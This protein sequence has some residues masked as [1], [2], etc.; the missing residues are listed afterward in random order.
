VKLF[1]DIRGVSR[2]SLRLRDLSDEVF[3]KTETQNSM[4]KLF[5]SVVA[6]CENLTMIVSVEE[7]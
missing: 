2:N 1:A 5:G 3:R 6:D 4:M 7:R